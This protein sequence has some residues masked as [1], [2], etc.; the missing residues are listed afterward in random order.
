MTTVEEMPGENDHPLKISSVRFFPHFVINP[1]NV[2]T[3]SN[4]PDL[5]Q[6]VTPAHFFRGSQ[7]P[8]GRFPQCVTFSAHTMLGNGT[9]T[10]ESLLWIYKQIFIYIIISEQ[11]FTYGECSGKIWFDIENRVSVT[12]RK[13]RGYFA[14]FFVTRISSTFR[15]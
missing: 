2:N 9:R 14:A 7:I 10:R 13:L 1:R 12:I 5:Y 6:K 8:N 11:F 3:M 4:R 15:G